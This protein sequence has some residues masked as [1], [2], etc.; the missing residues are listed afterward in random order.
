MGRPYSEGSTLV[1]S[2]LPNSLFFESHVTEPPR[3]STGSLPDTLFSSVFDPAR[4]LRHLLILKCV[5]CFRLTYPDM[6]FLKLPPTRAR[7]APRSRWQ[8]VISQTPRSCLVERRSARL[9][10]GTIQ[11]ANYASPR[12]CPRCP[13]PGRGQSRRTPMT[14]SNRNPDKADLTS[15][16]GLE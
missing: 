1:D 9:G 8:F 10:R 3:T 4:E 5:A 11:Y 2:R 15:D 12:A 14:R 6:G 13:A 16:N 7:R